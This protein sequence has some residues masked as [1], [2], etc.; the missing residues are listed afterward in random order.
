MAEKRNDDLSQLRQAFARPER[1]NE[2]AQ[3]VGNALAMPLVTLRQRQAR[4]QAIRAE[5]KFGAKSDEAKRRNAE[6]ETLGRRREQLTA[7][8]GR[9]RLPKPP[10]GDHAGLYG[11]ILRDGTP[12]PGV[13]V[14]AIDERGE[15]RVHSCTGRN[16]DY[17]LSFPPDEPTLIEVRD[18]ETPLFRD[19]SG[20]PYPA[21]RSV[22]RDIELT[23]GAPICPGEK[24]TKPGSYVQVPLLIGDKV[25]NAEKTID[26]LGLKLGSRKARA[27]KD[28]GVVLEQDPSAGTQVAAGSEISLVVSTADRRAAAQVGDLTGMSLSRA[29]AEAARAGVELGAVNL[30]TDGGR[31]PKVCG[32]KPDESGDKVDLTLSSTGGDSVM[33]EILATLLGVTAEAADMAIGDKGAT[34]AWLK[35]RD[36]TNL[37]RIGEA[38]AMDD[39]ALTKRLKLRKAQSIQ[40][41]RA[42]LQ[43][44]ASRVRKV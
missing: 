20:R 23:K 30:T 16:G 13:M 15:T 2:G 17:V 19:K 27:A 21:Y 44:A 7:E 32:S 3:L 8:I 34:A 9:Q 31:T 28:A 25:E 37:E 22:H 38:L 24:G 14:S 41:A 26:A 29:M 1:I 5:R 10:P 35:S 18:A 6:A 42:L 4:L 11:R 12:V 33:T 39:E 43:A 40:A 36:L